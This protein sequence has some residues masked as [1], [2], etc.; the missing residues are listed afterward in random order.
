MPAG[1][2]KPIY[3]NYLIHFQL[4]YIAL[5]TVFLLLNVQNKFGCFALKSVVEL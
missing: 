4:N 5:K 2:A 3:Q 1:Q